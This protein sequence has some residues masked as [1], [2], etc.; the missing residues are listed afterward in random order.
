MKKCNSG[1]GCLVKRL[2][3]AVLASTLLGLTACGGGSALFDREEDGDIPDFEGG[4]FALT[5]GFNPADQVGAAND[6][7][8]NLTYANQVVAF[9]RMANGSLVEAGTFETGGLGENIRNSGTNPLASQDPLI[10]SEDGEFLFAVNTGSESISSFAINQE[11]MTLEPASL[12][13]STEGASGG[14]NPVSLTIRGSVLYVANTGVFIEGNDDVPGDRNRINSSII[15]F[16]VLSDGTLLPLANSE[17]SDDNIAANAGSIELSEDGSTLYVTERRTNSII[18]VFLDEQGVPLR[19][20]S[21]GVIT[22]AIPSNTQQPF[23]TD[24]VVT[25]DDVEVLLVSEGNN[26]IIGL[27]AVSSYVVEEN[28]SL[29]AASAST[30]TVGDPLITQFTFGCW[31]ETVSAPNGTIYAYV[32]NTPDGTLSAYSVANDGTLSRIFP[33]PGPLPQEVPT[34]GTAAA[35]DVIGEG[36]LDTEIAYPYLYQVVSVG[37]AADATN[38]AR[39]AVFEIVEGGNLEPRFELNEENAEFRQGMFVGIAGV[40]LDE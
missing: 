35:G 39:I 27:S 24:I 40:T 8:V 17:I 20:T 23:G 28:G 7:E 14:Q 33:L 9:R 38:N 11:D 16:N 5:N 32:A 22:Q 34:P 36:V 26:G 4:I 21:G 25:S 15:G 1:S 18:R 6:A 29:T 13:M 37:D 3:Q 2:H 10:V 31:V 30:G 12:N 19:N